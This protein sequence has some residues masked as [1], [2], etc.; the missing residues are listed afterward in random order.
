MHAVLILQE[1]GRDEWHVT[2]C[3]RVIELNHVTRV[4]G[5]SL[6][7]RDGQHGIIAFYG[8]RGQLIVITEQHELC[9]GSEKYTFVYRFVPV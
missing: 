4:P 7:G 6:K 2:R 5:Q 3:Q 8:S 9:D 1:I